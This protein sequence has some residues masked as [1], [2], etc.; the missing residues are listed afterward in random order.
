MNLQ[1]HLGR[2]LRRVYEPAVG[3]ELP[4]DIAEL[5]HELDSLPARSSTR[6]ASRD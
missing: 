6:G 2:T 1:A 5:L 3:S 4:H